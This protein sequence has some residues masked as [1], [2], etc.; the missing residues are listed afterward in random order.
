MLGFSKP[1]Q[2]CSKVAKRGQTR[3][4]LT[5]LE[6]ARLQESSSIFIY[7]F[8]F[9]LIFLDFPHF[10]RDS[11]CWVLASYSK[12]GQKYPNARFLDG[13]SVRIISEIAQYFYFI[14]LVFLEFFPIY[15]AVCWVFNT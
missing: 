2:T 3:I 7:L 6:S 1:Q 13:N 12:L 14:I 10:L 8:R 5:E 9:L 4:F 15:S 11:L